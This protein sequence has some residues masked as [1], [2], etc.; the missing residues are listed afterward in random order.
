MN[1]IQDRLHDHVIVAGFGASGEE[2]VRELIRRGLP[3]RRSW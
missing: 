3:P 1:R 2:T